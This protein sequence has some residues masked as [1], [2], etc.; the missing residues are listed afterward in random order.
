[1][2]GPLS[3]PATIQLLAG[4]VA[5]GSTVNPTGNDG[6]LHSA[7]DRRAAALLP[8]GAG[9][10][11]DRGTASSRAATIGSPFI[12]VTL[13]QRTAAFDSSAAGE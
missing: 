4:P 10:A 13:A 6:R 5:P 12:E 8:R 7:R 11:E 3:P 1:M 2:R 9:D